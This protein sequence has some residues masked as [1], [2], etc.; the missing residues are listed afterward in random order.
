M[1]VRKKQH[2]SL[3]GFGDL[4]GHAR[5]VLSSPQLDK[6]RYR[7]ERVAEPRPGGYVASGVSGV[8]YAEL[9]CHSNYSFREGASDT[10]ELLLRAK[11]LGYR[12]LA[13]TDHDNLCGA[14]EFSQ[15]AR[16]AGIKAIID[17]GHINLVETLA[18]RIG[19]F[20]VADPRVLSARVRVEK[21]E[22]VAEAASAGVEIERTA[23][24]R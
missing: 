14:M 24:V 1:P 8:P 17:A 13:I 4:T 10:Q 19:D 9:H 16:D 21:L 7:E 22:A 5:E 15:T 12:A 3:G 6:S 11:E 18:E 20:C 2:R 23:P